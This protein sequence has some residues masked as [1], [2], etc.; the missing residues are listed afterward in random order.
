MNTS[1][2][3]Q[4]EHRVSVHAVYTL[5]LYF[6]RRGH[7]PEMNISYAHVPVQEHSG[8][9]ALRNIHEPTNVNEIFFSQRN[10][11]A[12]HEAIR[13]LVWKYSGCKHVISRQSDTE[14]Q[15]IMKGVYMDNAKHGNYDVLRQ[16]RDLNAL[17]L[18]FAVPRIVREINM[19]I[20]YR[21]EIFKNPMPLPHPEDTSTA[22]S[23]TVQFK[24]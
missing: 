24:L 1:E 5:P 17:V 16:V 3:F 15:V 12:L 18:D 19:Y 11:D 23:K 7:H 9:A 22:G 10:C 4:R 21:S 6:F 8:S 2:I 20:T 14:L 13:Y